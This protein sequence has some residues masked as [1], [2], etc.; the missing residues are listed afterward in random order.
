MDDREKARLARS[1]MGKGFPAGLI[2]RKLKEHKEEGVHGNDG[3]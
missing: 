1:L 3:E 2:I